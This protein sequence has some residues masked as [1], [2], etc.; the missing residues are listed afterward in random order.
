MS[1][2]FM[3]SELKAQITNAKNFLDNA[4]KVRE[5]IQRRL[6]EV[7]ANEELAKQVIYECEAILSLIDKANEETIKEEN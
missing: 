6:E 5:D 2:E 1:Y 3:T 4:P 7:D